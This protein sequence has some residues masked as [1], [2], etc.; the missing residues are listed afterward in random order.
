M[1]NL[2]KT[3]SSLDAF[4][5]MNKAMKAHVRP[6]DSFME[7]N[8]AM[9]AYT[10]P[11]DA[12]REMSKA[13]QA[14]SKPLESFREMNKAM[15]AFT[16]PLDSFKE[17]SKAMTPYT[18]QLDSFREL[19][20]TMKAFTKQLEPLRQMRI[21]MESNMIR[22]SYLNDINVTL[23]AFSTI[24]NL[25][26]EKPNLPIWDYVNN[27]KELLSSNQFENEESIEIEKH[28]EDIVEQFEKNINNGLD[29]AVNKIIGFIGTIKND[30]LRQH[31]FGI[32]I[33][34]FISLLFSFISPIIEDFTRKL[35]SSDKRKTEKLIQKEIKKSI[36][37]TEYLSYIRII[38]CENLN[39]RSGPSNNSMIIGNFRFGQVVTV[40]RKNRNWTL[41]QWKSEDDDLEITGWVYTRY[42]KKI[43]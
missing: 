24:E 29:N 10:R 40:V 4:R 13:M 32:F 1:K 7:M 38:S 41:V 33:T 26:E 30:K 17:I 11:L 16:K 6:L 23:N 20:E 5:E 27:E 25:K 36:P 22:S 8:K 15:I 39:V 2:H 35:M 3:F 34:I 9:R 37:S 43:K 42:L 18:R 31:L 21:V 14:Y 12:F 19:N 28:I